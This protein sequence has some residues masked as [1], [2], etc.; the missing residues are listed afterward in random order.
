M[1]R[2]PLS[3]TILLFAGCDDPA[4]SVGPEMEPAVLSPGLQASKMVTWAE[5]VTGLPAHLITYWGDVSRAG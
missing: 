4:G 3:F 1:K 5:P 2:F